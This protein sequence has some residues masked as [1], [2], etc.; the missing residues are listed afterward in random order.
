AL[1]SVDAIR[2]GGGALHV[3]NLPAAEEWAA[4]VPP[5]PLA[6]GRADERALAGTDEDSYLAHAVIPSFELLPSPSCLSTR[7]REPQGRATSDLIL[8]TGDTRDIVDRPDLD[9]P[10]F[11]RRDAAGD[12]DCFIEVRHIDEVIATELLARFGE[13]PVGDEPPA[14]ADADAGRRRDGLQGV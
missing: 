8:P 3:V 5:L 4:D 12:A 13:R 9:R 11:R 2:I 10:L 7:A 6:I 14:F 1:R